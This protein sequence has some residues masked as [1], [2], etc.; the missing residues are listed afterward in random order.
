MKVIFPDGTTL[1]DFLVEWDA[2]LKKKNLRNWINNKFPS[3]FGGYNTAYVI[4]HPWKITEEIWCQTKWAWQR[5]FRGWDDRALWGINYYIAKI[6]PEM[7]TK[8]IKYNNGIPMSIVD[9]YPR[10]D[11]YEMSDEDYDTASIEWDA[12]LQKIS[13]GFA[14]YDKLDEI[15]D[16]EERERNV[17][18][19]NKALELFKEHFNDLWY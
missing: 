13:D 10:N 3:G 11:S 18:K 6:L 9:K 7:L 4:T 14:L 8:F 5:V 2:E 1:E 15:S 19:F 12:I 16:K 17:K